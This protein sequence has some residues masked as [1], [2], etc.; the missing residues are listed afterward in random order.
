MTSP[1]RLVIF[2]KTCSGGSLIPLRTPGL[3]QSWIAGTAL[4]KARGRIDAA[5]GVSSWAE[6]LSWLAAVQ[7]ER[8]IG[9]IQLW[10][11]GRWGRAY[12]DRDVLDGHATTPG[13]PLHDA[14][15]DVRAR[16]TPDALWWFRTCETFGR[17]EGHSF[18][19]AFSRH[20]RCAVAGH[21]FIVGPWQ[22]GLHVL[23]PQQ[24]PT[25]SV[26]EGVADEATGKAL[27]STPWAP[28]TIHCL[29]ADIPRAWREAP[30]T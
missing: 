23:T 12:L 29:R 4:H 5:M 1:L 26:H 10:A 13:H 7:P 20:M 16:L 27:W 15:V 21:T 19:R 18:A 8:P 3:T 9:E 24:E 25:W 11:H 30:G 17:A 22:S 14:L 2:D 6:A 28:R